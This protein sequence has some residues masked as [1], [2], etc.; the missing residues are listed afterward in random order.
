MRAAAII[1]GLLAAGSAHAQM[2]AEQRGWAI[3]AQ[4]HY[5][6]AFQMP[7][8]ASVLSPAYWAD[9]PGMRDFELRQCAGQVPGALIPIKRECDAARASLGM[10]RR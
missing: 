2:T 10:T 7:N 5:R 1:A 3:L 6:L 4:E 9:K 8:P